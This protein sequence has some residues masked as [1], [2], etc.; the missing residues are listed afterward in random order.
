M[1]DFETSGGPAVLVQGAHPDHQIRRGRVPLLD[2]PKLP[3]DKVRSEGLPPQPAIAAAPPSAF[4][5]QDVDYHSTRQTSVLAPSAFRFQAFVR[6]DG[7][8]TDEGVRF[9]IVDAESPGWLSAELRRS[10]ARLAGICSQP[11]LWSRRGHT[12]SWLPRFAG[13]RR[14]ST[15]SSRGLS[16]SIRHPFGEP[17]NGQD[18]ALRGSPTRWT[19]LN[20]G[21]TKRPACSPE[22]IN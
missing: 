13:V 18:C 21:S 9:Q 11:R 3:I 14:S 5:R 12:S 20:R 22:C 8:T 17:V 7:L 16:G 4:D 1:C 15:I 19:P 10:Q 6:S 2:D